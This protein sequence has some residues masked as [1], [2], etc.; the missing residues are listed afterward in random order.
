MEIAAT[1]AN[2][3]A[4]FVSHSLLNTANKFQIH[5]FDLTGLTRNLKSTMSLVAAPV[6][7]CSPLSLGKRV[8]PGNVSIAARPAV[9]LLLIFSGTA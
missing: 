8:T 1:L 3:Q 4:E 7:L 5:L 9:A 2:E 6:L